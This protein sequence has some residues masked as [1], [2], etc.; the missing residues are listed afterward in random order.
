MTPR[1]TLSEADLAGTW[2]EQFAAWQAEASA[3]ELFTEPTA[4]VLST[5][6]PHSRT[7][8]VKQVDAR[9][10]VFFTNRQ[11]RKGADIARV[12]RAALTFPWYALSRQVNVVGTVVLVDDAESD[13]YFASRP[14]GAQLGAWASAQSA[15]VAGR[16]VLDALVAEMTERFAGMDVPRPPHWGGYRVQP[17]SVELWQGR[18]DRL[19]DRLR[20]RR[21]GEGW[22]IERLSP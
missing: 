9:G 14:R 5:D 1:G 8:L 22:V 2:W 11:S 19:H 18:A 12:P 6:G 15:V 16:G 13:A 21:E 4:A 17:E 7:V 20:Y 3:S 10:F